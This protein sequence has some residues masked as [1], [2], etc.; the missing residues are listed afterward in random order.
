MSLRIVIGLVVLGLVRGAAAERVIVVDAVGAPFAAAELAAAIRVRVPL[1]GPPLRVQVTAIDG[2]VRVAAAGGAR[3]VELGERRGVDAARL[4]ALVANDL[5][6]REPI[7][8]DVAQPPPSPPVAIDALASVATWNGLLAGLAIEVAIPH[9]AW[10]IA[11]DLGGGSLLG[12]PIKLEDAEA[13]VG[14]G[15]LA[16]PV[17]IRIEAIAEPVRV[18]TGAGDLTVLLG[19]SASVRTRIP[20]GA[21]RVVIA[22]GGDAF[23]TQ[24]EYRAAGVETLTTPRIAPWLRV[25]VEVPL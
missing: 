18:E 15:H 22:A 24:T 12:G 10:L 16:G 17:E 23:A 11:A 4:V 9:G 13:R 2:G 20:I 6:A 19:A 25:G 3:D 8:V 21:A 5:L 14:L 7:L 1:A